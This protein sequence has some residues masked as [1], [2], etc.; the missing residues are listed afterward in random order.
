[1][2]DPTPKASVIASYLRVV[3][4]FQFLYVIA[5][6]VGGNYLSGAFDL[7]VCLLGFIAV[8]NKE[9]YSFQPV[10]CYCTCCGIRFIIIIIFISVTFAQNDLN[11]K[12]V[13]AWQFYISVATYAIAPFIYVTGCCLSWF[14]FKEL[15]AVINEM[16]Q[17]IGGADQGFGGGYQQSAANTSARTAATVNSSTP[18]TGSSSSGSINSSGGSVYQPPSQSAD[19]AAD[20]GFRP[21]AGQGH[22]LGGS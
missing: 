2:I 21:F 3:L 20:A 17:N 8:K 10:L 9:G 6:F 22:R 15:R 14:L 13:P 16:A 19:P 11:M 12:D 5:S 18:A 4:L 1:L 7:I